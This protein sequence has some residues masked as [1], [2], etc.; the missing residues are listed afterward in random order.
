MK[1][2]SKLKEPCVLGSLTD[3]VI[4]SRH[5]S[6][7]QTHKVRLWIGVAHILE[8][9]VGN[10]AGSR[11]SGNLCSVSPSQIFKLPLVAPRDNEDA[12]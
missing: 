4:G 2:S 7:K 3:K 5:S 8:V 6:G 12:R 1:W 10:L 9:Y 11:E